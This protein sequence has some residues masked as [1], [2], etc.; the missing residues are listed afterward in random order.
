MIDLRPVR[1]A[2]LGVLVLGVLLLFLGAGL[3]VAPVYL[4]VT[5]VEGRRLPGWAA[6]AGTGAVALYLSLALLRMRRWAWTAVV[7]LLVLLLGSSIVRAVVSN[8]PPGAE[9]AEIAAEL[10]ALGYLARRPIRDAFR[11]AT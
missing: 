3:I 8:E 2:P 4:V 7:V 6:M 9:L 10:L 5:G 1:R 11:P